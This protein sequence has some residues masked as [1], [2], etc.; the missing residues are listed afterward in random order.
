MLFVKLNKN[1]DIIAQAENIMTGSV[2]LSP[3]ELP[4]KYSDSD[5]FYEAH[6]GY[7]IS[8]QDNHWM[9]WLFVR[10]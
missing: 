7:S 1:R 3:G 4:Q 2:Y 9:M 5:S 8:P 10:K 6:V